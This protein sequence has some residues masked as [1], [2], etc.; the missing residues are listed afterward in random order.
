MIG[1]LQFGIAL[2]KVVNAIFGYVRR[3]QDIDTGRKQVI[4]EILVAIADKVQVR[5]QVRA[6]VEAMSD[7]EVDAELLRLGN[8]RHVQSH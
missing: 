7:Q 2:L 6:K 8:A 1:W 4:A 3:Q 5:D